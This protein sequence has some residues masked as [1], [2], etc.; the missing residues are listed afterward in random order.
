MWQQL[1]NEAHPPI[2]SVGFDNGKMS[3]CCAV[4]MMSSDSMGSACVC[5]HHVAQS[6]AA[7]QL[8][9]FVHCTSAL[10]LLWCILGCSCIQLI[11]QLLGKR[12]HAY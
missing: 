10:F 4:L 11:Y 3:C 8:H 2:D 5:R 1:G 7:Q 9:E 12:V 6:S